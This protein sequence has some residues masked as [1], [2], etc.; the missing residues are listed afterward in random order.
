MQTSVVEEHLPGQYLMPFSSQ[1]Q[2][3]NWLQATVFWSRHLGLQAMQECGLLPVKCRILR[4]PFF[5]EWIADSDNHKHIERKYCMG[6]LHRISSCV[7]CMARKLRVSAI[8]YVAASLSTSD[9]YQ[10]VGCMNDFQRGFKKAMSLL[11]L[12]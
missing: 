3:Q 9:H 7:L 6:K 10:I 12:S 11:N 8:C 5:F 4:P 1:R 2:K